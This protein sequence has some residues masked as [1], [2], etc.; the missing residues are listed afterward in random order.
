[1]QVSMVYQVVLP[2]LVHQ[3]AVSEAEV[4]VEQ[5]VTMLPVRQA[6]TSLTRLVVLEGLVVLQPMQVVLEAQ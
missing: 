1:M 5:V 3:Q 4:Q 6:P 2:E